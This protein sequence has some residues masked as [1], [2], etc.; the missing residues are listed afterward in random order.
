MTPEDS[1]FQDELLR[2][3]RFHQAILIGELVPEALR[4]IRDNPACPERGEFDHVIVDEYQDLNKAE[5][6]LL[7][8][9]SE[10]GSVAAI[11]DVD[12]SIYR[13]R[14]A[15]PT[16]IVEFANTHAGTADK[17]LDECRRCPTRVVAIADHLI[18]NNHPNGRDPRLVP[19]PGKSEGEIHIVQWASLDDEAVELVIL[20]NISFN[21]GDMNLATFLSFAHVA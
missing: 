18:R 6:V 8:L 7:D 16:G 11:G 10:N 14:H 5:Q 13:F 20:R 9:L 2:W 15:H 19:M 3:L 21:C 12:Q 1:L 4:Y 17:E